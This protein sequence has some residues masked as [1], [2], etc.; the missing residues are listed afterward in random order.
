MIYWCNKHNL[1]LD[2]TTQAVMN[3]PRKANWKWGED[4]QA[5]IFDGYFQLQHLKIVIQV[6]GESFTVRVLRI[7][8][9]PDFTFT[10]KDV[11][12]DKISFAKFQQI[13]QEAKNSTYTPG[14]HQLSFIHP[15]E[16]EEEILVWNDSSLIY[17]LRDGRQKMDDKVMLQMKPITHAKDVA[18]IGG[19]DASEPRR[20][21]RKN[22]GKR[23][24]TA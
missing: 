8:D 4:R 6:P 1:R 3:L 13:L 10:P 14:T 20:L 9:D 11:D 19:Q 23:K 17:A 21:P 12:E 15:D 16:A 5:S 22:K 18:S 24:S 7:I 2:P